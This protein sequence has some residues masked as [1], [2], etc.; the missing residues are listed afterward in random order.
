MPA[1][2][3]HRLIP[4]GDP[5]P[6]TKVFFSDAAAIRFAMGALFQDG[7]DLWQGARYVGRVHRPA[8]PELKM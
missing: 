3:I 6:H 5:T 2:Q 8:A 7:C 1:Y 4:G